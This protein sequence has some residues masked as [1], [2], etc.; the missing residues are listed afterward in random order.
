M[1]VLSKIRQRT[2]LVLAIVGLALI[3]FVLGA[4]IES[5]GFTQSARNAGT[6]NGIDIPFEDFRTKVDNATKGQQPMT[7]MQATGRVWD[8]EVNRVLQQEQYEKI[9]LRISDDQ[10]INVFKE[11]P[12]FS[13]MPQVLNAAGKFDKGK[14]NEF[15]TSIKNST[16]ERW[17]QWLDYE[18][19]ATT[20]A[21][22][23][24]YSTMLRSAYYTTQAEGKF[25][26][27]LE[28]NKATIDFVSIPYTTIE[29]KKVALTDAEVTAHMKKNEDKYKAEESREIEF[30]T[31]EDKPSSEDEKEVKDRVNG[32]L[33]PIADN[34]GTTTVNEAKEGFRN[35]SNLIEFVNLNSDI[36]YDS[37]Y[38]AKKDLPAEHQEALFNIAPGQVYGPYMF[39]NFY[40]ITR[41]LG[42]K[43]NANVKASHILLSYKGAERATAT[44]TKE[45]AQAKANELLAQ[46]T[47]NPSSFPML[48]FTN[49][50]DGS[51]QQGGDLGYFGKGQMTTKFENFAFGNPVGKIGLV[52]TEFG[53]HIINVT[54]KQDA[55]RLATIAQ[56][57]AASEKTSDANFTKASQFEIAANDKTFETAAKN[58]KLTVSPVAKLLVLDENIQGINTPQRDIV[59]WAFEAKEDD[60]KRFN[61]TSGHVIARLKK[62][63]EA[64][65]LPIEEAKIAFGTK[66]LNEKKAVLI[67]EKMKGATLEAIAKSTGSPI[68]EAKDIN[69][70][71]SNI[72][73]VGQEPKVAGKAFSAKIGTVSEAIDGMSGV[74]KIKVKS[75]AKAPAV[76]KYDEIITRLNSQSKGSVG[77]RIFTALKKDADIEDNRA[78]FN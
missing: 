60:I 3:A 32:L 33:N 76:A 2:F 34:P 49:S 30:V 29:D 71:Y 59:R 68:K 74:F 18:K 14:F 31:V 7:I 54:D 53:F 64:G 77:G 35:A 21:V 41:S 10:L 28:N 20:F 17:Q 50:D 58:M 67:R 26:Y 40:C 78:Q 61:I 1:A 55:V 73:T 37:T 13:Q 56:K 44:R 62:V 39:G 63:N 24:M 52:E 12:Q 4:L 23:Q 43:S 70:A 69:A 75:I 11:D 8:Q 65:L 46:A 19:Q 16:P 38:V 22:E 72:E 47:A 57:I 9:G 45:E 5:G 36:K 25:A 27:E 15:V 6:I 48:A 42:K 51:K 66:L